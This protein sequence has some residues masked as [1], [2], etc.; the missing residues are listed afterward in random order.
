V[1]TKLG[2]VKKISINDSASHGWR[3]LT[4][5]EGKHILSDLKPLLGEW[6]IVAFEKGKVGGSGYGY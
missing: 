2:V 5:N 6:G 3:F 4:M 1:T